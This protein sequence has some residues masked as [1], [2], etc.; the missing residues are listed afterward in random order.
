MAAPAAHSCPSALQLP[1]LVAVFTHSPAA[2]QR[3]LQEVHVR[4]LPLPSGPQLLPSFALGSEGG[5]PGACSLLPK[6]AQATAHATAAKDTPV[7]ACLH[8][9]H[10]QLL[11][12]SWPAHPMNV[13]KVFG[14]LAGGLQ[15]C[16]WTTG[17]ALL[18]HCCYM[19]RNGDACWWPAARWASASTSSKRWWPGLR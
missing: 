11:P 19:C 7:G 9:H 3:L 8:V 5:G 6:L 1:A 18:L 17:Q 16:A 13:V 4:L 2:L 14:W 10:W 12:C 15:L